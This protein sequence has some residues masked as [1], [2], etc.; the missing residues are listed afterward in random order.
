M[1]KATGAVVAISL[2][3]GLVACAQTPAQVGETGDLTS[4]QID[5]QRRAEQ[6]DAEAQYYLG[7]SYDFGVGVPQDGVESVA[8]YLK[9][10]E[11]G[12]AEAPGD[13]GWMYAIGLVVTQDNVEGH[14]WLTIAASRSTGEERERAVTLRDD[15][16]TRMTPAD[17]SEAQRRAM[18]WHEAH[19]VPLYF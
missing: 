8:W 15:L 11:Q 19:P 7:V 12:H 3:A 13:L 10:A 2:A 9:A 14:M 16:A 17:L 4:D 5:Q 6:G 18:E 1:N